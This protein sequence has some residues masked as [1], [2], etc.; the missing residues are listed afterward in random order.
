MGQ[1]VG[2]ETSG[3]RENGRGSRQPVPDE[4][5]A[6]LHARFCGLLRLAG[7]LI[8]PSEMARFATA[9]AD[10]NP[11]TVR[12]LR[13][14][15][16]ITLTNTAQQ[17][18]VLDAV[19][20]QVF[21]GRFDDASR[22]DSRAP[23][24]PSGI[25]PGQTTPKSCDAAEVPQTPSGRPGRSG[26]QAES[27][28]DTDDEQETASES[29]SMTISSD[30][31]LRK[32]DFGS[33]SSAELVQLARLIAGLRLQP[34]VRRSHRLRRGSSGSHHDLRRTLR[35]S[36]RTAGD[37][38][39]L[40]RKV[41]VERPRRVVLL[42]DVS[43]SMERYSRAYLYLM[44]AAVRAL[45]AE[46]FTFA[47]QLTRATSVLRHHSPEVAL[48]RATQAAEDWSG[49]TRIGVAVQSFLDGWGRR[50]LARGAVIVIISDGWESGNAALLGEQMARL[51]RLAHRIIWVN[52]RKQHAE[53]QPLVAGMAAALPAIDTFVSG[54]SYEAMREV[55]AAISTERVRI[56]P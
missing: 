36:R 51:S 20:D 30:E 26:E 2:S 39:F 18:T 43:G 10:L 40:A 13:W 16:R 24:L 8:G 7:L 53:Y 15:A 56:E 12:E 22:G 1:G 37:P 28:T 38:I 14:I 52:P 32:K 42:A 21:L 3:L 9:V 33:C 29:V 34:P 5:V 19:F 27:E 35:A 25:E 45:E 55:I 50:G 4:D 47:T 6:A 31:R 54:H 17:R 11:S 48:H 23:L 44:H 46:A 41:R 49:G